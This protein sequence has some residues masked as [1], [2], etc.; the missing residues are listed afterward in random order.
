MASFL[1]TKGQCST[2]GEVKISPVMVKTSEHGR[3]SVFC[4]TNKATQSDSDLSREGEEGRASSQSALL[5]QCAPCWLFLPTCLLSSSTFSLW[6]A[7]L[8]PRGIPLKESCCSKQSEKFNF[9]ITCALVFVSIHWEDSSIPNRSN[10]TVSYPSVRPKQPEHSERRNCPSFWDAFFSALFRP[11]CH[12]E[13]REGANTPIQIN[14]T[15]QTE[16]KLQSCSDDT[17]RLT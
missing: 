8:S 1:K 3:A 17:L 11:Y 15:E 16:S 6:P 12:Q 7:T 14:R 10:A 4:D 5:A 13:V 2:S 9:R